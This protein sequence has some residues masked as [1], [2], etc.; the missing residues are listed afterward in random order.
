MEIQILGPRKR[1]DTIGIP[2]GIFGGLIG[3]FL[4]LFTEVYPWGFIVL[5]VSGLVAFTSVIFFLAGEW[6]RVP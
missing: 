1:L 4:V 5:A 3:L 2:I 6:E